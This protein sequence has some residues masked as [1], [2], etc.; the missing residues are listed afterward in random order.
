MPS[1]TQQCI[2]TTKEREG[3]SS[4]LHE[5][6][7]IKQ[8]IKDRHFPWC[9]S[10]YIFHPQHIDQVWFHTAT[11]P[12][13]KLPAVILKVLMVCIFSPLPSAYCN[14]LGVVTLCDNNFENMFHVIL[15]IW[16]Q[17]R[18]LFWVTAELKVQF[19]TKSKIYIRKCSELV[20]NVM[21]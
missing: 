11:E 19:F 20:A 14:T 17:Q 9:W 1:V 5:W 2:T 16:P 3:K 13:R 15:S 7:Y 8:H 18:M 21:K 12:C 6:S 4:A 10:T